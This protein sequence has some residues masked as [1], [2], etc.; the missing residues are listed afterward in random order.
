MVNREGG[1]M[2][3]RRKMN[4]ARGREKGEHF[5]KKNG[6]CIISAQLAA[7]ICTVMGNG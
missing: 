5:I 3:T 6:K 2:T 1:G 7:S 4:V